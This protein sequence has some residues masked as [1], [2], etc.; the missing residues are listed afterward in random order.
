MLGVRPSDVMQVERLAE[1]RQHLRVGPPAAFL[2]E[3][4]FASELGQLPVEIFEPDQMRD[5]LRSDI[6]RRGRLRRQIQGQGIDARS[7]QSPQQ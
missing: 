6:D 3:R 1:Q 4:A 5:Q 2:N 7:R